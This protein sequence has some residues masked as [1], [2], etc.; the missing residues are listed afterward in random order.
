MMWDVLA[1]GLAV[2]GLWGLCFW[3]MFRELEKDFEK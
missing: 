3:L 2:S 1:I